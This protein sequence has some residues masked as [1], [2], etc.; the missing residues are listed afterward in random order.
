MYNLFSGYLLF[1]AASLQMSDEPSLSL[2]YCLCSHHF[3]FHDL[4]TTSF[5]QISCT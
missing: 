4:L 2:S 5:S 3:C 1:R